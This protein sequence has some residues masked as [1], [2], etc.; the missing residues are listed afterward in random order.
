MSEKDTLEKIAALFKKY[1]PGFFRGGFKSGVRGRADPLYSSATAERLKEIVEKGLKDEQTVFVEASIASTLDMAVAKD[2]AEADPRIN[3]RVTAIHGDYYIHVMALDQGLSR[4]ACCLQSVED[5]E[6]SLK[7]GDRSRHTRYQTGNLAEL[8]KMISDFRSYLKAQDERRRQQ[9]EELRL[10]DRIDT[11]VKKAVE[12]E[13]DR[14]ER[15]LASERT[16]RLQ[17]IGIALFVACLLLIAGINEYFDQKPGKVFEIIVGATALAAV[18]TG[19]LLY[20]GISAIFWIAGSSGKVAPRTAKIGL[21]FGWMVFFAL[22][23]TFTY[24]IFIGW[25]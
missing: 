11:A 14:F 19:L 5:F 15:E 2:G 17:I 12:R 21:V 6:E 24:L 16:K 22:W 4:F 3:W 9:E 13:R 20:L 18:A 1:E 23:S 7:T 25:V 8:A 10:Q